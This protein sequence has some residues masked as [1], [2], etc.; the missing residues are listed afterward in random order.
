MTSPDPRILGEGMAPTPFTA[1]EIRRGCPAGRV[2]VLTT[3]RPGEAAA[4]REI[5]FLAGDADTATQ[6]VTTLDGDGAPMGEGEVRTS[7]WKDLQ[8][9]AS[10]PTHTTTI[11]PDVIDTVLGTLDCLRYDVDTGDATDTFWFATTLPGMPVR[12]TR[13]QRGR[14]VAATTIT[15]NRFDGPTFGDPSE[16]HCE[17]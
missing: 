12:F 9:H 1:D 13:H 5:R 3:E 4:H 14:L 2:I 7:S 10:F 15:A 11:T 17:P 16:S 8:A 6:R